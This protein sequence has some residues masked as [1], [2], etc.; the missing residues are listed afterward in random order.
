[1][2]QR[3][4]GGIHLR[5]G[6]VLSKDEP[7]ITI[8]P[9]R[10]MVYPLKQH[11][12]EPAISIVR[13]GE[14]VLVGQKIAQADGDFSA[15]IH[16][17]VSGRVTAVE[18][19]RVIGNKRVTSI[20]IENDGRYREILY[21]GNR[22]LKYTNKPTVLNSIRE[23]GIV[24]MGG[25]GIPTYYKLSGADTREIDYC[26]ANLVECEPYLTSDYRRILENPEKIINGLKILLTVFPRARGILA[27]S[28]KNNEG[29][30]ILKERI[31][32][33]ERI[34]VKR[35]H[36]RYPSGSERQLIYALTGRTL[37]GKMLPYDIG[38]IV[39]NT[40]TLVA[41]NQAVITHEPLMT[42]IITVSGDAVRHPGNFRV[43]IGMSYR[44]IL[45]QAGGLRED[46]T[47]ED[48]LIL[49]G[50]PMMGTDIG[51]CLDIPVTKLSS[52]I[53]CLEKKN[54]RAKKQR[55]CCRCGKCVQ[56]CPN[57]LVPMQLYR[58]LT[59]N[60][61]DDFIEHNGLECFACGCCSYICPSG[62]DLT[63]G[64]LDMK[65]KLL[66]EPDK[67]GDYAGR[68]SR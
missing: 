40:D 44:E 36:E 12:G 27:V 56:A 3:F 51:A 58:D 39:H 20:V 67:A 54:I 18:K 66:R 48:C 34:Q 16:S 63:A 41:I 22:P 30:R 15:N 65:E 1:M 11:M 24:G 19:R 4:P 31:R 2:A 42:R 8:Y 17:S 61:E 37:N 35:I 52:G 29:Y 23:A 43:R 6:K 28:D 68:Y 7:I 57:H 53:I 10:E 21:P 59:G 45:S 62:I 33:D 26:I 50:G 14:L 25:S 46:L 55:S 60:K 32:G 9:G 13:P 38:C 64:I 5:E 47:A 49:D